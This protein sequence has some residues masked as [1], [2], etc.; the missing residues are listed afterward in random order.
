[1]KYVM[2]DLDKW[3]HLLEKINDLKNANTKVMGEAI[4]YLERF[5]EGKLTIMGDY[6]KLIN[7]F[8]EV[9]IGEV[10]EILAILRVLN[11]YYSLEV[12][13]RELASLEEKYGVTKL[14]FILNEDDLRNVE[15]YYSLRKIAR[16]YLPKNFYSY[17][18]M[19]ITTNGIDRY[20]FRT[21]YPFIVDYVDLEDRGS[22]FNKRVMFTGNFNFKCE[23]LPKKEE[24]DLVNIKDRRIKLFKELIDYL[25]LL[26]VK[27]EIRIEEPN[28]V[29]ERSD[30][31]T[32]RCDGIIYDQDGVVI[33]PA[34]YMNTF[35]DKLIIKEANFGVIA[36][37]RGKEIEQVTLMVK[38]EFL[39]QIKLIEDG[40]L[41]KNWNLLEV[42]SNFLEDKK[43]LG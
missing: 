19:D 36:K 33:N 21:E 6:Y 28:Q 26:N 37:L 7:A 25:V 16:L 4:N 12:I 24:M 20:S 23:L 14:A 34:K 5:Q 1:M 42:N 15:V 29:Y 22:S 10:K 30:N 38:P 2:R 39:E 32:I 13:L 18:I 40:D 35:A 27:K 41:Q 17:K 3:I 11:S 9:N 8:L 31:C 43:S